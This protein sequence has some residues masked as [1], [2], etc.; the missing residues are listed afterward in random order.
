MVMRPTVR[1]AIAAGVALVLSA[2]G[3]SDSTK[4]TLARDVASAIVNRVA[5]DAKAAHSAPKRIAA[6]AERSCSKRLK[7]VK[8]AAEKRVCL[9]QLNGA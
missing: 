8:V 6:P 1:T 4:A 2:C 3:M 5:R 7:D 9:P